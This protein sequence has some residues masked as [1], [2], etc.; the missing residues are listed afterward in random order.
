MKNYTMLQAL[1]KC[2]KICA[3][4]P[5]LKCPLI[6]SRDKADC[7]FAIKGKSGDYSCLFEYGEPEYWPIESLNG[8]LEDGKE[9]V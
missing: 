7:P 8:V 9:E 5:T 4:I 1:K 2:K 6:G 3:G